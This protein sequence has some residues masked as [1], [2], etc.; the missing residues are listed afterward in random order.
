MIHPID[1]HQPETI[2]DPVAPPSLTK[3]QAGRLSLLLDESSGTVRFV[4]FGGVEVLR[5]IYAAVRDRDWNTLDPVISDCKI[6]QDESQF[7]IS[8]QADCSNGQEHYRWNGEIRGQASGQVDYRFS[9]VAVTAIERNRIGLCVLHPTQCAGQSAVTLS[10]E[11]RHES[12]QFP[13]DISPHQP[14]KNLRQITHSPQPGMIVRVR[15]EGD[16]FEMEDQRNWTDASFKTY[17]TPLDQ[18]FPIRVGAG[19]RVEQSVHL[20][21]QTNPSQLD[22]LAAPSDASLETVIEVSDQVSELTV[23]PLG[24]GSATHR[25]PLRQDELQLLKQLNL[26][27]LRCDLD[28][29]SGQWRT[30]LKR[31]AKESSRLGVMLEVALFVTDEGSADLAEFAAAARALIDSGSLRGIVRCLVFDRHNKTTSD[32]TMRLAADQL[33][34]LCPGVALGGGTNA[35]FAE[36]NR[37]PVSTDGLDFGCYSIN[38]QVHAFDNLSLVETLEVQGQTVRSARSLLKG[39]PIVVSPVTLKPRFNPNATSDATSAAATVAPAE[40]DARQTTLFAAGWTLGSIK[41]LA[42]ES[43]SA[44]TYFETCG[45]RGVIGATAVH[46]IYFVFQALAGYR[47]GKILPSQSSRPLAVESLVVQNGPQ[48]RIL[49]ANL[50]SDLQTVA[51]RGIQGDWLMR[52]LDGGNVSAAMVGGAEPWGSDS[53]RLLKTDDHRLTMLMAPYAFAVLDRQGEN[54]D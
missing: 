13:D 10:P 1:S 20:S 38:P 19:E 39:T 42:A 53:E 27:H 26:S 32:H 11:G 3:L 37:Q 41:H 36:L 49:L 9:G 46:P 25:R 30:D 4:R 8:F 48:R 40:V 7:S 34:G 16:T 45:C 17:C 15:M 44:I 2:G 54:R 33:G 23:P 35:Y 18:P 52:S 22:S 31:A 47:S 14:M 24:L 12:V 29:A 51:I 43:V 28:L 6:Q 50:T 5:G 21:I